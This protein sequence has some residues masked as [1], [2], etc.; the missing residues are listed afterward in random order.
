MNK[1]L[2]PFTVNKR[3]HNINGTH[4]QGYIKTTYNRLVEAFGEPQEGFDKS[5]AEWSVRFSDGTLATIYD[6]RE[7]FTPHYPYD[8]HIGGHKP[9][10]VLLIAEVLKS[11]KNAVE[12]LNS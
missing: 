5:T 6:Y 1:T 2:L 8:W 7:D 12:L 11:K 9:Q 4:L 10:A 3:T